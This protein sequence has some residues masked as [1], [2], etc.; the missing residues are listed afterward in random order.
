V[1]VIIIEIETIRGARRVHFWLAKE[2]IHSATEQFL[3]A[4]VAS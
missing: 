4:I 2:M 3:P 1:S